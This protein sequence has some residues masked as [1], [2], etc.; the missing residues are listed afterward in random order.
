[1]ATLKLYRHALSGH[2]H[3]AE[4]LLSL[5][6]LPAE[7]IDVDLANG[8][9]KQTDF[10]QKNIFGQVPVLEDGDNT[11]ADSNAILTYLA[12]R[13]DSTNRWAP[14][15]PVNQAEVQR[16]L[17][18]AAGPLAYGPGAARLVTVFGAALDADRAI[19]IAHTTL[20]T[21]EKHLKGRDWLVSDHPTIADISNYAYIAHAPE[22]NV[23]LVDYPTI[24]GWLRR[25]EALPG[26]KPMQATAV[27]LAA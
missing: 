22:G 10:L 26:F 12:R 17:S 6:N 9:H 15:D 25:I 21:L 14:T 8:A 19:F 7:I 13:Y 2:S 11:I 20:N 4:L 3:R 24:R 23:S 1:M 18:I 5:L 16:F 27:G